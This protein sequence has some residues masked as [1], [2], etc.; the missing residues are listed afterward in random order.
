MRYL[1]TI[2]SFVFSFATSGQTNSIKRLYVEDGFRDWVFVQTYG[3]VGTT[4]PTT[5]QFDV[6][7]TAP[8]EVK[9]V[10]DTT[11]GLRFS[12]NFTQ[13][14][15]INLDYTPSGGLLG[16]LPSQSNRAIDNQITDAI[17]V[18]KNTS[19]FSNYFLGSGSNF[20]TVQGFSSGK[21]YYVRLAAGDYG[22]SIDIYEADDVVFIAAYTPNDSILLRQ[23]N[24]REKFTHGGIIGHPAQAERNI[25][26]RSAYAAFGIAIFG[27]GNF[28]IR[29]CEIHHNAQGVQCKTVPDIPTPPYTDIVLDYQNLF[30]KNVWVHD[31]EQEAWYIGA[32][33]AGPVLITWTGYGIRCNRI[34]RDAY[35]GRNS[36]WIF[37][38]NCT[39]DSIGLEE[40]LSHA[41]GLNYGTNSGGAWFEDITGTNIKGNGAFSNGYGPVTYK[42]CN[43]SSE[44][45][46]PY[47]IN[48][49][50][51]DD[52]S[53]GSTT[54][55]FLCDNNFVSTGSGD[56]RTPDIRRDPAKTSM[57]VN[58]STGT[59]FNQARYIEDGVNGGT[60]NG[61]IVNEG[62]ACAIDQF[63]KT[64]PAGSR[65][66][67][68]YH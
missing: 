42:N 21:K 8:A 1:L 19:N 51:H 17:I 13:G 10:D 26:I 41:Q 61:I 34:G 14:A 46:N 53:I 56:P 28:E 29:N 52:Q 12:S 55:Y 6:G 60:N 5:S 57:T 18:D 64:I 44:Q 67:R 2:L 49:N 4:A 31:T 9:M 50:D 58:I 62:I 40:N 59:V 20:N 36:K 45:N 7:G 65:I 63:L 16:N 25:K 68:F 35:Q 38:K 47:I 37:L 48:Y 54:V 43:I 27:T 22:T 11:V 66:R 33:V 32:D 15:S 39:M 30:A 3:S 24:F 23:V